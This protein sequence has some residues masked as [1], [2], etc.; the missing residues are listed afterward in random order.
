MRKIDEVIVHCSAT[1]IH[2]DFDVSDI[3]R[4]H[5]ER[6]FN[7]CGYHFYIKLSGQLQV[8][9]DIEKAGA[10]CKGHNSNTV[11][12]CF[13]GGLMEDMKTPW[14]KPTDNQMVTWGRLHDYFNRNIGVVKV[15]GHYQYST[16][17]CPN[18]NIN[19]LK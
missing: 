7:G 14:S 1:G 13:E 8:G 10:H 17:T 18:F 15:S 4:W 3:D 19:L 5:R 11:G 12:V 16:K 9:R 6:G 2:Q